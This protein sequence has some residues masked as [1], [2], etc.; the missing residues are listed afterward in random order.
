MRP[1]FITCLLIGWSARALA[2]EPGSSIDLDLQATAR[3]SQLMVGRVAFSQTTAS[4]PQQFGTLRFNPDGSVDD[5]TAL[6]FLASP[7]AVQIAT[8][9]PD[10]QTYRHRI[11][12]D[13]CRVDVGIGEGV[14]RNGAWASLALPRTR[15][16]SLSTQQPR[17]PS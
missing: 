6:G 8:T 14:R 12:A 2:Q 13:S 7:V 16:P 10:D 1:L 4:C 3:Y 5:L 17:S 15:R 9:A 11:A